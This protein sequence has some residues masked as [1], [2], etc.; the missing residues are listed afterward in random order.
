MAKR[1][2]SCVVVSLTALLITSH[3]SAASPKSCSAATSA[4]FQACKSS[5]ESDGALAEGICRNLPAKDDQKSCL[6][7]ARDTRQG[8]QQDCRD[9]RAARRDVCNQLGE[10]PYAP[11][12]APADFDSDF[13]HPS[14]PNP[15]FPLAIGDQWTYVG[16]GEVDHIEI[17]NATKSIEGVTCVVS[18]DVV[19]VAGALSE[20]TND[21]IAQA[22]NG[23]VFYCGE[24]TAQFESFPGDDPN[25]PEMVGIEGSFKAGRDGDLPGILMLAQPTV[26]AIYR[27]EFSLGTAEDLADVLST[28]YAFGQSADLDTN[29]PQA[30]AQLLCADG[31]CLV[32]HEFSPL[33]PDTNERKY[34]APGIGDFLEIEVE[35]GTISQLTDCNFDP[36]CAMLPQP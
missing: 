33:E 17:R 5:A 15:L 34:Y 16:G 13:A 14:H 23:D 10:A 2:G 22:K 19:T 20:D 3:A 12:F 29:V 7:D 28:T 31:D 30:L 24:Q 18:H 9:Q 35:S 21:W 8:D 4:A 25:E 1:C 6:A 32:T 36:R 26:G 11:S 27:Q